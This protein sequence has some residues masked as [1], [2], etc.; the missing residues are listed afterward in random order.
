MQAD[1][2]KR[3]ELY[4]CV[5]DPLVQA[6]RSELGE[7]VKDKTLW[8]EM[9]TYYSAMITE[10]KDFEL[11]ET[12]FNSVTRRIFATVGVN[13][14]IEFVDSD[15]E[16]PPN[17]TAQ[18]IYSTFPSKDKLSSTVEKIL[19]SFSFQTPYRNLSRDAGLV[20]GE[21]Q[22]HL[23]TKQAIDAFEIVSSVFYRNTGAYLVGRIR[24]RQEFTPFFLS[25]MNSVE[26]IEVDAVLLTED[27]VSIAFSF[28]H[29]YF[30]VQAERPHEL[31]RFL[32]SVLPLKRVAELYISIGFNKHGKTEFYRDLR[33]HLANSEDQ[34]LTARGDKGMVMAV[35]TMPSY[36]VVFKIIKDKFGDPKTTT[37]R[38][39]MERYQLVFKHDRVG[40]LIDAQEFEHLQFERA[41][42]SKDLLNDLLKA[43]S[44]TVKL[45]GE[46]V[47]IQHLYIER[48]VTPL[49]LYLSAADTSQAEE[50]TL[51]YGEAIKD[52]ASANIFP[53]DILLKN[54]GVT[55]HGRVVFYDYDELCLLTDCRFRR[56][57]RARSHADEYAAEPWFFVDKHDVF[58]EEFRTFL[59]LRN[60]LRATFIDAHSELFEVDYWST[61]QEGLRDGKVFDVFPYKPH[62]HLKPI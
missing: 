11:I 8:R 35:F 40:R 18:P 14:Q 15:F 41:R 21:I 49:N 1:A 19:R 48:R 62:R 34:F 50:A 59:G 26:G 45:D 7:A 27:E 16:F 61:M 6:V 60:H 42:F 31:I 44:A 29:S 56:I 57:P 22:R 36:D 25:L 30:H 53:G 55:R 43:A 52:L 32:K 24:H 2:V 13:D 58:P 20:A 54:F 51:D 38:E 10:S 28:A 47:D 9:K 3:L 12:F 17:E 4:K 39:V 5:V 37:R 23:I 46:Y 33:N